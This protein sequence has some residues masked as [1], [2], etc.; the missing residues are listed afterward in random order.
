MDRYGHICPHS[1]F[2]QHGSVWEYLSPFILWTRT[3]PSTCYPNNLNILPLVLLQPSLF[4]IPRYHKMLAFI[5]HCTLLRAE[6]SSS[7]VIS[8]NQAVT[9]KHLCLHVHPNYIVKTYQAFWQPSHIRNILPWG[10]CL[11]NT[12]D[13]WDANS[14]D[15][16]LFSVVY[17]AWFLKQPYL[18]L[19]YSIHPVLRCALGNAIRGSQDLIC[20][21]IRSYQDW[22]ITV[23]LMLVI[24]Q[25]Y[26]L[27]VFWEEAGTNSI[28]YKIPR[29]IPTEYHAAIQHSYGQ[30]LIMSHFHARAN[31]LEH[32]FK[33]AILKIFSMGASTGMHD[34]VD[35]PHLHFG[36]DVVLEGASWGNWVIS[37]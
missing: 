28:L 15:L 14:T 25:R 24:F 17:V 34:L 8:V 29:G 7:F 10:T 6:F 3:C 35:R 27:L 22:S 11:S 26:A 37:G 13:S 1:F 36:L 33:T 2:E 30:L 31:K 18:L 19:L 20:C 23:L 21:A 16:L 5:S 32:A 9:E 12:C 4:R